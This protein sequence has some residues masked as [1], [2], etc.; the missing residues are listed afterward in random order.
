MTASVKVTFGPQPEPVFY[1]VEGQ[2]G[3]WTD[4]PTANFLDARFGNEAEHRQQ[5]MIN[6]PPKP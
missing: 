1:W 3:F 4:R 2:G 5:G 6:H